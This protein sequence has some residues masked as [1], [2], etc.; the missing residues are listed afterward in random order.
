MEPNAWPKG[1]TPANL[2]L[3]T[4]AGRVTVLLLGRFRA[5]WGTSWLEAR[6]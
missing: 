1:V 3:A 2:L 4:S 6:R 5:V